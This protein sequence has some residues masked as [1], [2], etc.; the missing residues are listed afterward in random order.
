MEKRL[1]NQNVKVNL[2]R[3]V[4]V[5]I[6]K[7]YTSSRTKWYKLYIGFNVPFVAYFETFDELYLCFR[8]FF[9]KGYN[10]RQIYKVI[11]KNKD[12]QF[13]ALTLEPR[14]FIK[15]YKVCK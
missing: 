12:P 10:K 9:A 4:D 15:L 3:L 13:V 7:S 6:F 1:Q 11:E 14:D 2:N 8:V 5:V